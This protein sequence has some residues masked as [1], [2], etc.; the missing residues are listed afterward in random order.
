MSTIIDHRR[1]A[2]LR[3]V[4]AAG[5]L[6]SGSGCALPPAPVAAADP[7]QRAAQIKARFATPLA[8]RDE[9]FVITAY[10]AQPC[11][12]VALDKARMTPAPASHDCYPALRDAI[13]AC[14]RAGGGRV[15]IPAGSWYCAGPMV[16]LSNVHVHLAAGAQLYFSPNPAHFALYGDVDCGVHGKLVH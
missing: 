16:L 2:V 5:V 15:L 3:G 7:W 1:R 13:A 11:R 4:S 10:G 12:V 6:L 8:F 9:D 14:H